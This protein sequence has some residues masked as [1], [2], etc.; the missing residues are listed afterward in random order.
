ML[1][2]SGERRWLDGDAAGAQVQVKGRG[3]G[4]GKGRSVDWSTSAAR[5]LSCNARGLCAT[6]GRHRQ[7][8]G[9]AG[10]GRGAP[11][12]VEGLCCAA[13]AT[14][15]AEQWATAAAEAPAHCH[16]GDGARK[17]GRAVQGNGHGCDGATGGGGEGA[18]AAGGGK[19]GARAVSLHSLHQESDSDNPGQE[20]TH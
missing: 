1:W 19:S 16:G 17:S 14:E 20:S 11:G 18:P 3:E 9:V 10:E 2:C 13:G 12:E 4:T 6:I 7:T 15:G 8:M 5:V